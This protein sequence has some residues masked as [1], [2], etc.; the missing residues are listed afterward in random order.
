[1]K[2]FITPLVALVVFSGVL[3]FLSPQ[4]LATTSKETV[5]TSINGVTGAPG[6]GCTSPVDSPTV[7]GLIAALINILSLAAG[8]VAIVMIILGAMKYMTSGGDGSAVASAKKTLIYAFV[9][10]A[11]ASL[12]QVLVHY[13]L[14]KVK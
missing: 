9:G 2:R 6:G 7:F 14:N 12:T 4:A 1:M 8:V 3:T 5:C 11:I 10:L 13:V